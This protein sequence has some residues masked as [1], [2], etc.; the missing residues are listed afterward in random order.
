[1]TFTVLGCEGLRM[2]HMKLSVSRKRDDFFPAPHTRRTHL[3]PL[4]T[5]TAISLMSV[6]VWLAS[7]PSLT[8]YLHYQSASEFPLNSFQ[9][10]SRALTTWPRMTIPAIGLS[11]LPSVYRMSTSCRFDLH[12]DIFS[13]SLPPW[14]RPYRHLPL[15]PDISNFPDQH[16]V[17]S[18]SRA[19]C[20]HIMRRSLGSSV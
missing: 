5:Y 13:W 18:R 17:A 7:M 8:L 4:A 20:L 2:R 3:T 16:V 12:C 14:T 15:K 19:A 10:L 9:S 1:M 6:M 11:R